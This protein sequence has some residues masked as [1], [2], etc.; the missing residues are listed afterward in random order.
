[1]GFCFWLRDG[2]FVWGLWGGYVVTP[3]RGSSHYAARAQPDIPVLALC[4]I[5][6]A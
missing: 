2:V 6:A 4:D 1:M 3:K 5:F